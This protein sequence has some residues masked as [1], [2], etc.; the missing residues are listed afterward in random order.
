MKLPRLAGAKPESPLL[1]PGIKAGSE[2]DIGD[3]NQNDGEAAKGA[4]MRQ[5]REI[6]DGA[7]SCAEQRAFPVPAGEGLRAERVNGWHGT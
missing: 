5:G 3:F 7:G 1:Q 4:G 6:N 2:G